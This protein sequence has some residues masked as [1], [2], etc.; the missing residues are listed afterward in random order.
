MVLVGQDDG[1]N[2][3]MAHDVLLREKM[4]SYAIDISESGNR[5]HET[6]ELI[7]RKIDL[8]DISRHHTA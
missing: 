7:S 4:H 2:E 5:L 1:L 8:G 6:A 3:W